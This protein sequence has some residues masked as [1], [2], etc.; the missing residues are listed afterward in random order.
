MIYSSGP[1]REIVWASHLVALVVTLV[2][3]HIAVR[4]GEKTLTQMDF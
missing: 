3:S 1:P 2:V 4:M